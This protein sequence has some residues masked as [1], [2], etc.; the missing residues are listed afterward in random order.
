M[1]EVRASGIK[2]TKDKDGSFFTN[3]ETLTCDLL[4]AKVTVTAK[5]TVKEGEEVTLTVEANRLENIIVSQP[6]LLYLIK[7][8]FSY[9]TAPTKVLLN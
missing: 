1:L 2:A 9:L 3:S 8:T 5:E 7:L 4:A 6:A